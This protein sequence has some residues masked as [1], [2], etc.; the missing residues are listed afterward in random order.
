MV[1]VLL[2]NLQSG[3]DSEK[4][5]S[6]RFCN[7][8]GQQGQQQHNRHQSNN[9]TILKAKIIAKNGN[10]KKHAKVPQIPSSEE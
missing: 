4:I 1:T 2:I 9:K 10:I 3:S 6:G 8:S 5:L 7:H